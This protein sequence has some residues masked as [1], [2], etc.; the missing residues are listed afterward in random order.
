MIAN[1]SFSGTIP[2]GFDI[3]FQRLSNETAIILPSS[4]T[5]ITGLRTT[6]ALQKWWSQAKRHAFRTWPYLINS[7]TGIFLVTKTI[8]TKRYAHCLSKGSPGQISQIRV[9][10]AV[11]LPPHDTQLVLPAAGTQ[12]V[13]IRNDLEFE[14]EDT[15]GKGSYTIFIERD[16]SRMFALTDANLRDEAAKL[17]RYFIHPA[18]FLS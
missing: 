5:T 14:L 15:G 1:G 6:A 8:K 4:P 9:H 18:Q 2:P 10:G 7:P 16:A 12:W 17:W 11:I 3:Y 13:P